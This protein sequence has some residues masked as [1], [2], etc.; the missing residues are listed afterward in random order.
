MHIA[1]AVLFFFYVGLCETLRHGVFGL[2]PSE[3]TG[4]IYGTLVLIALLILRGD[5]VFLVR[6]PTLTLYGS[7]MLTWSWRG[8]LL[9]VLLAPLLWSVPV[10]IALAQGQVAYAPITPEAFV[11]LLAGPVLAVAVAEELFFREAAIKAFQGTTAGVFLISALAFFIFH[12]P[13]G[14]PAALIWS[15]MGLFLLSLRLIGTNLLVVALIHAATTVLFTQV[16]WLDMAG[17]AAWQQA[18][19]ILAGSALLSIAV[20]QLFT[21]KR[22]AIHY[23]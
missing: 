9:G 12:L 17:S 20:Y 1:Y 14:V 7:E 22:S 23:A 5:V 13:Q 19:T 3:T 8:T 4:M 6:R 2:S 11:Q 15:G 16:L 18:A 21:R 10:L